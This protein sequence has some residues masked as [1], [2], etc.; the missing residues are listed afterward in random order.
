LGLHA[1][2]VSVNGPPLVHFEPQQLLYFDF[3][4]DPAFDFDTFTDP[5]PDF[6]SDDPASKNYANSD[7]DPPHWL[8]DFHTFSE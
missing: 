3:E 1:A 4:A 7:P 6:H 8:V 2:I 5:D